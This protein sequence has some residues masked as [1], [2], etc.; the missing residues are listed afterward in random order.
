MMVSLRILFLLLILV[1]QSLY[2]QMWSVEVFDASGAMG[3]GSVVLV[4]D[5]VDEK[6][7]KYAVVITADHVVDS[8]DGIR[9]KF[10]DGK[11]IRNC[12]VI[13]RNR[14]ADVATI[15]CKVPKDVEPISVS[16]EEVE[17]G[18]VL[19]FCGRYRRKFSGQA[20]CLVYDN[21]VWTD[22]VVFPG[23]SGGAVMLDGKLVAVVSG[24]LRWAANQPQRT[25]P[26]RSCNLGSIRAIIDVA[27]RNGNWKKETK[28]SLEGGVEFKAYESGDL[29][30]KD[31]TQLIVWSAEW[32]G[33]C[34]NM[35]LE[36]KR[37][38]SKLAELGVD[39]VVVVDV[40]LHKRLAID[41]KIRL[42]PT[43]FIV[44]NGKVLAAIEGASVNDILTKLNRV[45]K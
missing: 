24:G 20:S 41:N 25:W 13:S 32:C 10:E 38:Q 3:M 30:E 17:E 26:C 33:P 16:D 42:Y 45:K 34:K 12:S 18:D 44:K 6:G 1:P 36:L 15:R 35:K 11:S 40:D 14:E 19:K 5:E 29:K 37:R 7:W 43:T 39:R 23:D 9:I 28:T 22:V 8:Q 2:A 4:D 31:T 21:E 27:K